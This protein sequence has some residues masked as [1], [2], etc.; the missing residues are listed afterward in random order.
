MT[1]RQWHGD[2]RCVSSVFP[3]GARGHCVLP[4]GGSRLNPLDPGLQLALEDVARFILHKRGESSV[5]H[6][7]IRR[8]EADYMAN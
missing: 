8:K 7:T 4:I 2:F 5:G 1:P 6:R 3:V